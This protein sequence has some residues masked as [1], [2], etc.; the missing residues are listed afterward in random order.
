MTDW[1]TGEILSTNPLVAIYD[2]V[3]DK[4]LADAVIAASADQQELE[5]LVGLVKTKSDVRTNT[6]QMLDQ[7]SHPAATEICTRVSSLVRLP[8]ENCEPA[9]VM[10][11]RDG[12]EFK[13]HVDG[14]NDYAP[15]SIERLQ[16]G[17]QRVF[18]ALCYLNDVPT[19][20]ETE[21]PL[22]KISVTPKLG[23]VL[24]FS[25]T[26]P[27]TTDVHPHSTHAGRPVTDGEKWAMSLWWRERLYHVPRS[28]PEEDGDLR[29]V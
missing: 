27:G 4:K 20:G 22:L 16:Y 21:F 2:N 17:G 28:Y 1:K 24:V 13:P 14:L 10:R 25:N 12:E 15:A 9:K 5:V 29:V 3:F 8:P 23:R 11:Y 6:A 18:T 19:G 26:I 7:W